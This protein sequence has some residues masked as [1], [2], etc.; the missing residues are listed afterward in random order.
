VERIRFLGRRVQSLASRDCERQFDEAV[1]AGARRKGSAEEQGL[2][3]SRGGITSKIVLTAADEDT[4]IAD[5]VE[6]HETSHLEPMLEA[7]T[8]RVPDIQ[9]AVADKGFDGE[10]QRQACRDRKI[11]PVIPYKANSTAPG[12]L[13]KKAYRT[14]HMIERLFGQLKAFRRVATRYEKLK[15]TFLANIQLALGFIRLKRI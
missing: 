1:A 14:R 8:A 3:R 9:K 2:G 5:D 12:R 13:N 15:Q 4:A 6:V 10:P 7:T 11:K